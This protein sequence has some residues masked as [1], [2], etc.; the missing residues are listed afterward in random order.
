MKFIYKAALGI[1]YVFVC[2]ACATYKLE[3]ENVSLYNQGVQIVDSIKPKS[4]VR[5]E[6][7]QDILGGLNSIP[8]ALFVSALNLSKEAVIFDRENVTLWQEDKKL[9]PLSDGE[10]KNKTFDYGYI[11]ESYHLSIPQLALP[12]SPNP[13]VIMPFIYRGYMG[14]FYLYDEVMLSARDRLYA[15]IKLDAQRI[16]R[17]AV[18]SNTLAKN[19]LQNEPRGG[20]VIYAPQALRDGRLS[21]HVMVGDEEHIFTLWLRK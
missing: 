9:K 10:L 7:G 19:T 20:F 6:V 14:G 13:P 12:P 8:L 3:V 4:K 15:Q 5:L 21:L 17:A 18:L 11:V 2:T 1:I 16:R